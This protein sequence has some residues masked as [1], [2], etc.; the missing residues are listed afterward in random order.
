MESSNP[1]N[2]GNLKT[3]TFPYGWGETALLEHSLRDDV[4]A[5]GKAQALMEIQKRREER[6]RNSR[7]WL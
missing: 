5:E 6:E 2:T 7:S 3:G 1:Y 4:T